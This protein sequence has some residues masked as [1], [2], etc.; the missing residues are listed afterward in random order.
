VTEIDDMQTIVQALEEAQNLLRARADLQT[1]AIETIASISAALA[2]AELD[3][4]LDRTRLRVLSRG[5][6]K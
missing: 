6:V 1:D 4:A 5:L 2:S 3:Q